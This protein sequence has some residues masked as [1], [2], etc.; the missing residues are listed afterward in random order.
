MS[1]SINTEE[2]PQG[3]LIQ[4]TELERMLRNRDL[5]FSEKLS[6]FTAMIRRNRML[7]ELREKG[8]AD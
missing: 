8:S 4:E 2:K 1:Q 5:P 7:K 3:H 6:R